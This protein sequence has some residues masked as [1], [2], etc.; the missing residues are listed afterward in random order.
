MIDLI[1]KNIHA[2]MGHIPSVYH[3]FKDW[4][5]YEGRVFDTWE[6]DVIF[7]DRIGLDTFREIGEV[8]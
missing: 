2:E 6:L 5:C 3:F 1:N 7:G 4:D 8:N